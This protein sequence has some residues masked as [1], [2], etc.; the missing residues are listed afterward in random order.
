MAND[1]FVNTRRDILFH[2]FVEKCVILEKC[3]IDSLANFANDVS[4]ENWLQT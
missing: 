3:K 4:R 1:S 2:L